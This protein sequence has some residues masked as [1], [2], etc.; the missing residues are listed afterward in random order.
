MMCRDFQSPVNAARVATKL[1]SHLNVRHRIAYFVS[2]H[3]FGH[4]ARASAVM[5]ALHD[6]DPKVHFDVFTR[7]PQWF[8]DDS[9]CGQF[10]YHSLLTDIGLVQDSPL[11][12]DLSKTAERLDEFLPFAGERLA[13]LASH[14]RKLKCELVVCDIAPLGIAVGKA[15]GIPTVLVENFTWDWIYRGYTRDEPRLEKPAAYMQRVFKSADYHIQ[16]EPVCRYGS[17]DVVTLPVSRAPRTSR[18]ATREKL[19]IPL[20][21]KAALITMGGI[22]GRY[23][24]LH[25]LEKERDVYF[26]IPGA[27]TKYQARGNVRLLPNRSAFF[28]PDLVNAIDVVVGKLGYS[29]VAEVYRAGIPLV[30]VARSRFRESRV[31]APFV[32]KEMRGLE[33]GE[34]ELNDGR[35]LRHLP[36]VLDSPRLKRSRR[37]GAAQAARFIARLLM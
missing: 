21:A 26:V 36:R 10:A 9:I 6:I 18:A 7:V 24:F 29:T 8:F 25:S 30:Y 19:G 27:V 12:E 20:R 32:R 13:R 14:V 3:G 4:A 16:T 15:A 28:H 5:T 37:D 11:I 35:W 17:A 1:T 31:I 22:P 34:S 33:I 2:P 23:E